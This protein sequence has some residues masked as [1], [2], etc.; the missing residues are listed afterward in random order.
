MVNHQSHLLSLTWTDDGSSANYLQLIYSQWINDPTIALILTPTTDTQY[1]TILPLM[2]A[3]NRTFLNLLDADPAD[4]TSHYPYVWSATAPKDQLPMPTL[5]TIN[6]QAQRYAALVSARQLS[7]PTGAVP[8]AYG[9]VSICM[10]THNDTSQIQTCAGVREWINSTNL[11]RAAQGAGVSDMV[12]LVSDVFWPLASTSTDQVLY[13]TTFDTCPDYVDLLVV[14]GEATLVDQAAVSGALQQAQ[15]SPRAAYTTST[16]P[17]FD[18]TNATMVTQ[19][20]GW[21]THA[22]ASSAPATLPA[23]TFPTKTQMVAAFQA[24]W[25]LTS[26]SNQ[27]SLCQ[28]ISAHIQ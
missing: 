26:V 3:S 6:T 19:W 13:E 1:K 11:M 12:S 28:I 25:K 16:L 10:Y 15:L 24:Y 18:P 9:I 7:M 20:N 17:S 21:I 8:S 4:F 14:C 2:R 27:Q 22:S 23:P 5:N